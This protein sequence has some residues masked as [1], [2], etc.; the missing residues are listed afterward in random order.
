M[1]ITVKQREQRRRHIGSSDAPVICGMSP[2]KTTMADIFY[3]KMGSDADIEVTEAM[4]AG[5]R[6]EPAIIDYVCEVL[7]VESHRSN[8]SRIS[9]DFRDKGICSANFD[10][11]IRGRPREAIEAKYVGPAFADDWGEPGTDQVPEHVIVQ[12]QHQMYVADLDRVYVGAAIARYRLE[13]AYYV[14]ERHDGIINAMVDQETAFW[15]NH[16]LPKIPPEDSLPSVEILKA[17]DRTPDKIVD[18]DSAIVTRWDTLRELRLGAE[19]AEKAAMVILLNELGDAEAGD[20]G[21]PD[22]YFTYL[23]QKSTPVAD[24][25]ALKRDGLYDKYVT[26]GTHRTARIKKRGK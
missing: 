2:Y 4:K 7:G 17:L 15:R 26:Q 12:T 13:W 25:V 22:R 6:L 10:S 16:V 20:Y 14:V 19:R 23:P 5:N 21:N 1:P 8:L 18:I 9:G 11:W 24:M 3:Q